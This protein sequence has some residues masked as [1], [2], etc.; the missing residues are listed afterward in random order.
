MRPHKVKRQEKED[1]IYPHSADVLAAPGFHL[2]G[3]LISLYQL[4]PDAAYE[5]NKIY[6]GFNRD[7]FVESFWKISGHTYLFLDDEDVVRR[8][9]SAAEMAYLSIITP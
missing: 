3:T 8:R 1:W 2:G 9:L 5:T 7:V 4:I 6:P